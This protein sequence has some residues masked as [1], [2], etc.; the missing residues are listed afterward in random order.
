MMKH[1]GR[2]SGYYPSRTGSSR[3][4]STHSADRAQTMF[5]FEQI[6]APLQATAVPPAHDDPASRFALRFAAL[7]EADPTAVFNNA[8]ISTLAREIFGSSAGNAR[9]AYDAA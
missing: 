5:D 8:A 2:T 6:T 4:G 9:D 1:L 3:S 7:L